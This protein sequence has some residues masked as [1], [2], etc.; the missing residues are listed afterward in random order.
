MPGQSLGMRGTGLIDGLRSHRHRFRPRRLCRAR[1]ARR[2]SALKTAVVEKDEDLR[3]HLPEHRLHPVEGAA[4]CVRAVRRRRA[5][6]RQDGHQG[7]QPQLDLPAMMKFKDEAVD[8]NVKGVAFLFKKNKIDSFQGTGRIAAPGKVEVKRRRRQ[9]RRRSRPRTS[10]SPPARTSPGCRASTID[11][12]R[13][14]SSTGA[15]DAAQGAEEAAGG[16]RRRDRPR[17][18]L[19]VAAARRRGDGG[20]IPRP[21]RARH[22]RRSL[23][24]SSSASSRSRA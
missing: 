3:R 20:R 19:G 7:R 2:S 17:A 1:S 16:R 13:I 11:E 4:A 6:F 24:A 5:R 14:V 9:D 15:L 8:G 12:K 18:R 10:S 23:R 21:H 22:R